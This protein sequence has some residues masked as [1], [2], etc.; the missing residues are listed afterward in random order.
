LYLD[1]VESYRGR[2]ENQFAVGTF[3]GEMVNGRDAM[4][5]QR[6]FSRDVLHQQMT[7]MRIS[8]ALNRQL[9][10]HNADERHAPK[11]LSLDSNNRVVL[12][13]PSLKRTM[14]LL[15]RLSR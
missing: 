1:A 7:L 15:C 13:I 11:A 12:I 5:L 14:P 4:S 2:C 9:E 3:K 10:R 6:L 8:C